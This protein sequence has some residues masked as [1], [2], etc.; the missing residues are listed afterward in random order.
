MT[1]EAID[2][3]LELT[4]N[5]AYE[6]LTSNIDPW[7]N[8]FE[9]DKKRKF[10]DQL[11]SYFQDREEYERCAELLKIKNTVTNELDNRES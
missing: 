11:I 4:L 2:N 9:P 6:V 7:P 1:Q 10:I 8:S 5:E 3:Y